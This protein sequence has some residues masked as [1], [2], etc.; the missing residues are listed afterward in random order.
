MFIAN[1]N[2]QQL[3]LKFHYQVEALERNFCDEKYTQL[4]FPVST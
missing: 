2:Q 4:I 1:D 3:I